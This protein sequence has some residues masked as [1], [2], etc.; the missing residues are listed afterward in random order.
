MK[1]SLCGLFLLAVASA[2]VAQTPLPQSPQAALPSPAGMAQGNYGLPLAQSPSSYAPPPVHMPA[3][4]GQAPVQTPATY[5]Q[6]PAQTSGVQSYGLPAASNCYQ[7]GDCCEP[8]KLVCVREP[9]TKTI[10]H[11]CYCKAC[12]EFCVPKCGCCLCLCGGCLTCDG[13]HLKYY[14]VKRVHKEE[15]PTTKCVPTLVPACGGCVTPH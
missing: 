2:A 12:E 10:T 5:G 8:T 9:A 4:Y 3:V 15:C 1:H 13:P 7:G 11:V 6:A 14:L